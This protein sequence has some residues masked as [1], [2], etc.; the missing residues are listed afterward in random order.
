VTVLHKKNEPEDNI[1]SVAEQIG[2]IKGKIEEQK[3]RITQK[4]LDMK[5]TV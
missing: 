1:F 3:K 2:Q 5:P 4:V